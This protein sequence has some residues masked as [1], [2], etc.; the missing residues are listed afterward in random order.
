MFNRFNIVIAHLIFCNDF[1]NGQ[2]DPLY[3]RLCRI[4]RYFKPGALF[5]YDINN[6]DDDIKDIYVSLCEKYGFNY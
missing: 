1:Y 2:A 3:A 5:S 6:H 4:M